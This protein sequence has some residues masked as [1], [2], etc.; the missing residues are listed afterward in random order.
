MKIRPVIAAVFGS[1]LFYKVW[2]L[3]YQDSLFDALIFLGL[4]VFGFVFFIYTFPKDKSAYKVTKNRKSYLTTFI[5]IGLIVPSLLLGFKMHYDY[6]KPSLILANIKVDLGSLK[7]DLKKD[8]TFVFSNA[9]LI[10]AT[11]TYGTYTI[12]GDTVTLNQG[13]VD[14]VIHSNK[15]LLKEKEAEYKDGI[16]KELYLIDLG[17]TQNDYGNYKVIDDNR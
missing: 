3:Q 2:C 12:L 5:L 16:H 6:T 13:Q 1:Y 8:G 4:A 10:G 7:M 9:F 15:M 14:N 17:A 11:Y